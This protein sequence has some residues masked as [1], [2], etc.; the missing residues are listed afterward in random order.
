MSQLTDF[1][2]RIQ[3]DFQGG[4]NFAT[5]S[6]II[7]DIKAQVPIVEADA[8]ALATYINANSAVE[9]GILTTL[10]GIAPQLGIPAA[11]VLALQTAL[12]VVTVMVNSQLAGSDAVA[13]LEAGFTSLVNSWGTRLTTVLNA[14]GIK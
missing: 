4:V 10:I 7:A 2:H 11:G 6:K 3:Q 8:Q 5:A 12:G 13:E 9:E 1:V 14:L